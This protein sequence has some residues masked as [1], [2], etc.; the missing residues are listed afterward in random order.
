MAAVRLKYC[1]IDDPFFISS[2]YS[3]ILEGSGEKNISS[4]G[5]SPKAIIA[6]VNVTK[7]L[8]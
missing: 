5:I 1:H 7:P 2:S 4:M 3:E 6:I 8:P